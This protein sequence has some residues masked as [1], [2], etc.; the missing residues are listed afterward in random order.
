MNKKN[1]SQIR[2]HSLQSAI[3]Q[4]V[5]RYQLLNADSK[6]LVAVSGGIDS[7]VMLNLLYNA[8]VKIV[9][10]HCNF[11]LRDEEADFDETFVKTKTEKMGVKCFTKRFDTTHY[12]SQNCISI[13]M[14]ARE[15]RY[16]WF[17]ELADS[18]GLDAIAV[19]HNL[20]DSIETLFIN[21]ARGT[22]INGLTGI[23]PKN[24]KIVRPLLFASRSDIETYA[25]TNDIDFREDSSNATDKY[26]RNYIRN[27][28]IPCME[29][30]F[31][32]IKQSIKRSIEHFSAVELIYSEAIE[33]YKSQI[34]SSVDDLFYI[35]LQELA[36]SPSSSTLLYEILKP[37]GFSGSTAES[38]LEEQAHPSGRQFFNE[39]YRIIHDRQTLIVQKRCK[40]SISVLYDIEEQTSKIDV[41]VRLKIDKFDKY[42]GFK[43]ETDQNIACFDSDKLQF[44]LLL[45][46]WHKGDKFRPLGMKNMKKLSDFFTDS[47]LSLIEKEKCL[48]LVS[49]EQIAWIVGYRIDDRFKITDKTKTVYRLHLH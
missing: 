9:A 1:I 5:E 24:G 45:R 8:D 16:N 7:M 30:F 39:K 43:P 38:I 32:A 6:V 3:L 31:P 21:L 41:P 35:D 42:F 11:G 20:D 47:K 2:C 37:F 17:H 14:A 27:N 25:K 19:A 4:Y 34:I 26:A 49:G 28:I 33:R 29:Q 23:K 48:V 15:L 44:P 10:A 22:G 46:N 13:Q 40:S 36:K 12:A 18:E